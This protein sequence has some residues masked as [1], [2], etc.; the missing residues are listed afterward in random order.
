LQQHLR[1]HVLA[2]ELE[3]KGEALLRCY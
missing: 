1:F 3:N 2:L